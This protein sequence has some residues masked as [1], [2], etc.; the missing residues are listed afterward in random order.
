M[1]AFSLENKRALVTGSSQGIGAA[2]AD[3]LADAGALV[4]RHGIQERPAELPADAPYLQEDLLDPGAPA[5]LIAAAGPLDILVC[6]A[7]GFFDLPVLEMNRERW[8]RTFQL[9]VA[10]TF[11]IAQAFAR[12]C[13]EAGRAGKI[14]ITSSTNGFQ[15]ETD[16][17]AY[18]ASKGALVMLTR[19]LA[20]SLAPHGIRVNGIAPG[21]VATKLTKVTTDHPGRLKG[22]LESIPLGRLGT[23]DDMAGA[24]LFLASPLAS[25]IVGQ[26][27]I[28]DGGLILR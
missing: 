15:A 13:V 20:V 6:N 25:Y 5:R 1:K 24:A 3:G 16:S 17:C 19:S 7:G 2:I 11:F 28:V 21:L 23:P 10:S 26:T 14:V 8:E 27:I 22:A 12:S 9:N 18:D 4:A